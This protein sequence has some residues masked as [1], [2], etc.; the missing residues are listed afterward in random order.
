MVSDNGK[1]VLTVGLLGAGAVGLGAILASIGGKASGGGGASAA[2]AMAFTVTAV[3]SPTSAGSQSATY[4]IN[5][6]GL[7]QDVNKIP[8][9]SA[10]ITVTVGG[11]AVASATTS[12]SGT[13]SGSFTV[14][15][16][17]A[18]GCT[19]SQSPNTTYTVTASFA[20]M[21]IGIY[22]YQSSSGTDTYTLGTLA[23]PT[24]LGITTT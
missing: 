15:V 10:P 1:V 23:D 3:P 11:T 4:T 7:L 20:G 8:I 14:C 18:T 22:N 12:S 6:N 2:T 19:L 21:V 24:S 17:G 16:G 13:F 9:P 5:F